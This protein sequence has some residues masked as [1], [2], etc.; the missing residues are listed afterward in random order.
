MSFSIFDGDI[1]NDNIAREQEDKK[2]KPSPVNKEMAQQAAAISNKY[3]TLPAGAVVGAARLN[4][5]PDDPRLKQIVIQNSIIKDEEG[6]GALKTAGKF[7]KEKGKAGLRGLFLGFQS[8]WEEGLPEKVRYLEAR[9]QGMTPE[10]A[11]EA[12]ETELFKAGITG[13]GDLGDGLFLGST[14]PTTTDEYKN[15]VESGVS[16]VD[17]RQFVLDNVLGPQIYEEQRLKAETGVQFQGERRAKFEAAG[18]APTVTIGRWLFKPFDEV[19]E[20]G[21]KAYSFMTGA[22]DLVA[23]IFADPIALATFGLSKVGKLGKT[24]TSLQDMKKFEASGLVNAA[25]K[26]IHGPTSQAFLAGDEG[27]VFKKF[28][29]ENAE[30]GNVII[31]QSG[32]QIVDQEFFKGLRK[33]KEKNPKATYDDINKQL[34]DFVDDYLVNKQLTNNMLPTI[35]KKTNRLSKMMDKTYGARMITGDVDGSLVQMTRLLNL[36]TD[37]LDA[38]AAQKLSRKYFNKTLDA[39]DSDDAPTEVVNTLV[40]FFQK[41]FKNPI[42]K[43]MGGK[44]NKDGSISGLSEFQIKLIERGTNVMGKFYADGEMAK[45]A[46]RKYSNQD[47]PMTSLLQKILKKKGKPVN[48]EELL[49]SPLTVTQLAD[50]IFLPNPTDLLRVSKALDSKLGPVGNQFFAGESADTVRRFMDNYYGG[51]FKPLV[52]LRPA[53][54][55]RVVAEEQIRIMASGVTSPIR[56][57]IETIARI[58][59]VPRESQIGLLGSFENNA[60]FMDSMTET[61]GT[62]SS[63]RR[64]YAGAG[65]WGTVDKGKNFNTWKNASFRNVLQAYFDP[66]SKELAAIQLLPAA[67]RAAAL[68]ALKKRANTKGSSL[69]NHIKK[70]TGAKSHMFNGAGRQSAP[71]KSLS[72]EFINYV[73]ANLADVAGGKVSTKTVSGATAASS[74]WIQETGNPGLLEFIARKDAVNDLAGLKKVDFDAYWRGELTDTEYDRITTQLRK[75]QE[76]IKKDFFEKYLDVLPTTAKAELFSEKR[77]VNM[78]N[79]FVDKAFD[80]LMSKPTNYLS[81][82][83]AFK[84][85]YWKKV[86][87]IAGHTNKATLNK[88]IKQAEKAGIN[89]GT[90]AERKVYNKIKSYEG[91]VGGINDIEIVDKAAASFALGANKALL[92]DVN[93]RTR[94]GNSTRALFPFGEAFVEIFTTWAKIIKQERGRPLRRAQ[95]IVQSG[96]KEGA[97][98][99]GDDQKGFFYRDPL[100]QQELFNYP[101]E[102]LLRKWMFK[103]LE[104]NGIQVNMPVYLQSVN[105]AANVIPGFGPTITVPAAF[106]NEKFKIFEPEGVAQFILFGDFS[107]PRAGTPGEVLTSLVP[108]PSYAKKFA[109]AFQQNSDETKR[110]FNNTTIEVYK[111]LLYAGEISDESPQLAAEGLDLAADYAQNILM[112]RAFAQW[113]GP[114]GPSS[115]KYE[116]KDETGR[117]FLFETLAQEW[118]DIS[119]ASGDID[120]AMQEFTTRFGFDPIAIATAKTETIKKRPITA[121]GAEWERDNP[122]LVDKFD[123]TYGFLIDEIDAEFSYDA[124]WNQ[125]VEGERAPRTPEQWQRA[126]NILKGNLEFEAWLIRN[127]LVNKTDKVSTAAKR[128][129]KAELASI[130]YGYGL[131]IPGSIKK[132]ELDEII[133]ELY[134]WFN[135]VT[136]EIIPELK[137]QPVAQALV[138]YIKERDKV[139]ELTTNIPGTNYL[140]TSFRTSAKLVPFRKHLRE[141][142]NQIMI[143]YPESK[144]LLQEVFERELRNEY[145]DQELLK[146]LN[147]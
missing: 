101:G 19:I 143:K 136:Y 47:L 9:Q 68:R 23:Q 74:R 27:L 4:I 121:D 48:E 53:W 31:K 58:L 105:L 116:I 111:A 28:L 114:A 3:P 96:R 45:T 40:E 36:A 71:G 104:E 127:D 66:L 16:P 25:R 63:I 38:D 135:P 147:E 69:N 73:N 88:L 115:P 65:T 56:H 129:K 86:G 108:F 26:T 146:A 139:I 94:L 113:I 117:F 41:D 120:E 59:Q 144:A 52:L 130:Y 85:N 1:A 80:F 10:E 60:Q 61:A 12:S 81:R 34:T 138:E 107:P 64:R 123:L 33:L 137:E 141:V 126:K 6:F 97:K 70:V 20:P 118:R 22:I 140:A 43:N 124:Y 62:L 21:T 128:N 77:S 13:K 57:P 39:L 84:A 2:L 110:L 134:T 46:G 79:D 122:A 44:I 103:D 54:T 92:Y 99:E 142:K 14:D 133:M 82:S 106:L 49:V 102:G 7:A 18:V 17:A 145:E 42:V 37:Q 131:A 72:D 89:T 78:A 35:K 29:W 93:T 11:K 32:E 125:I 51:Y 132:P 83:V 91:Q 119:T 112:F 95:Q 8:A 55:L 100:T 67:K 109:T 75:N 50:E 15:L 24:F 87:E 5:S 90:A 98:F 30:D 76:A